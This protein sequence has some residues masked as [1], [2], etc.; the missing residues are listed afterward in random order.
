M[1]HRYITMSPL[2]GCSYTRLIHTAQ[3]TRATQDIIRQL[4]EESVLFSQVDKGWKDLMR[5]TNDNPNAISGEFLM[6]MV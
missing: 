1:R 6:H 3:F 5:R 2:P 4:P